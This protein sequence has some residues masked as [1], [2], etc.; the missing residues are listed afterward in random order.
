MAGRGAGFVR[1]LVI[2]AFGN[3]VGAGLSSHLSGGADVVACI[4][5]SSTELA[6]NLLTANCGVVSKTLSGITLAIGLCIS[7]CCTPCLHY[8][9]K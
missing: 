8:S 3:G 5:F 4:V 6:T 2:G 1:S 9:N 7:V